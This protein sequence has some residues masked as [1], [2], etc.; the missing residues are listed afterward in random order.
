ML[1]GLTEEQESFEMKWYVLDSVE[2]ETCQSWEARTENMPNHQCIRWLEKKM[3]QNVFLCK[4]T[5]TLFI[6]LWY[7]W[8]MQSRN[9]AIKYVYNDSISFIIELWPFELKMWKNE[10]CAVEWFFFLVSQLSTLGLFLSIF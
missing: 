6:A 1:K 2:G 3:I 9:S 8:R 4:K 7:V 10:K 5:S